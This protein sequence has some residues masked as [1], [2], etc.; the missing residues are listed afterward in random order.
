MLPPD[1]D[2]GSTLGQ[3]Y[4]I[5]IAALESFGQGFHSADQ[6]LTFRISL[7][8]R[9]GRPLLYRSG[10]PVPTQ[11]FS[12]SLAV[13]AEHQYGVMAAKA[14]GVGDRYIDFVLTRGKRYI[15]QVAFRIRMNE[16]DGRREHAMVQA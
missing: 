3:L 12:E 5:D 4:F 16:I 2:L 7:L 6:W 11:A 1:S 14:H 15:I 9:V 8:I 13:S 10:L